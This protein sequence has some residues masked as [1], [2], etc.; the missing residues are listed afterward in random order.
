MAGTLFAFTVF[1]PVGVFCL[2]CSALFLNSF[3]YLA[4]KNILAYKELWD[5]T[6]MRVTNIAQAEGKRMDLRLDA[7]FA[8][9]EE[10]E[11][12]GGGGRGVFGA[13]SGA[14]GELKDEAMEG[15]HAAEAA[16]M[17]EAEALKEQAV[18]AKDAAVAG[19]EAA[20][21]DA[22]DAAQDA[23]D[24]LLGDAAAVGAERKRGPSDVGEVAEE[25]AAAP[26]Q[27][28]G[29]AGAKAP[30]TKQQPAAAAAGA[31]SRPATGS[32]QQAPLTAT[33]QPALRR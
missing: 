25:E 18:A 21:A 28:G 9:S 1:G 30:A 11:A 3:C 13:L 14:L 4:E 5:V 33:Q 20:V 19:A 26:R 7:V 6:C 2:F 10:E 8:S 24:A 27:R 22:R 32:A 17:A 12:A 31:A 29:A 16:A 23:A 15:V